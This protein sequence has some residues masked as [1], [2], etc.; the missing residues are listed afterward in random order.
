MRNELNYLNLKAFIIL[1]V[2]DRRINLHN[3][4]SRFQYWLFEY[5]LC[6]LLT[7]CTTNII[8]MKN[9]MLYRYKFFNEFLIFL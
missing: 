7:D 5:N 8:F 4:F 6:N 1:D 9:I 3:I 2:A